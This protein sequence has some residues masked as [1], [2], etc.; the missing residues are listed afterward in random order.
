MRRQ[1]GYTR[2]PPASRKS[3]SR[4]QL[5][6]RYSRGTPSRDERDTRAWVELR[7]RRGAREASRA[8]V[9]GATPSSGATEQRSM[10]KQI[11]RIPRGDPDDARAARLLARRGV[12]ARGA[13]RRTVLLSHRGER[14]LCYLD[15]RPHRDVRVSL[16]P[17]RRQRNAAADQGIARARAHVVD[18]SLRHCDVDLLLGRAPLLVGADSA[19]DVA[20][21]L[22]RRAAVDVEGAAHRGAP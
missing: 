16:S 17:P 21:R 19:P 9:A 15:R 18:H 10:A 4:P 7:A 6:L 14:L 22:R 5:I 11:G 8:G 20:R 13:R 2:T 1:L 3:A 12:D